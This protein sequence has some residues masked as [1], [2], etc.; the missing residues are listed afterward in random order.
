[1]SNK[2][3]VDCNNGYMHGF[4]RELPAYVKENEEN[5]RLWVVD[6]GYPKDEL[7]VVRTWENGFDNYKSSSD[8]W[9]EKE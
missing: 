4:P 2:K 3:M 5:I 7:R 1:M 9:K 8:S 6:Q